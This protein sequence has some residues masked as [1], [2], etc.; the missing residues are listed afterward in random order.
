ML[1]YMVTDS[2]SLLFVV[3][4]S[5]VRAIDLDVDR[6]TLVSLVDFARGTLTSPTGPGAIVASRA[7][8]QRLHQLLI[9]PAEEAGLLAGVQQLILVP[10]AELHYLPFAALLGAGDRGEYLVERYDLAT[11][12]SASVWLELDRRAGS[13]LQRGTVCLRWHRRLCACRDPAPR[14]RQSAGFAASAPRCSSVRP[15]P[16]RR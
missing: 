16:G 5:G 4:R 10:H 3:T 2:T 11:V 1:E 7:P 15:R 6:R 14:S 12:P 8:L 9:Q 13:R